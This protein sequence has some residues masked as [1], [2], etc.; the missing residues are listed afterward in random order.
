[1]TRIAEGGSATADRRSAVIPRQ[2]DSGMALADVLEA[3]EAEIA[4]LADGSFVESDELRTAIVLRE[5]TDALVLLMTA[6]W[7]RAERW[8]ADGHLTAATA[9]RANGMPRLDASRTVR[10][11][12]LVAATLLG[13]IRHLDPELARPRSIAV[14]GSVWGGYPNFETMVRDTF[15]E[16]LGPARVTMAAQRIAVAGEIE[17]CTLQGD[18]HANGALVV[19]TIAA[20][21]AIDRVGFTQEA[22][23][24]RHDSDG[25][26]WPG[27]Q[28]PVCR[29]RQFA[30]EESLQSWSRGQLAVA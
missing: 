28:A 24:D 1:M 10:A 30:V 21:R 3:V 6:S 23:C 13:T 14:D 5:R 4:E 25:N 2:Y 9:L 29:A 17:R 26:S 22:E 12:R 20:R 19:P 15:A 27:G 8:R 7:D 16:R 18:A 11:A